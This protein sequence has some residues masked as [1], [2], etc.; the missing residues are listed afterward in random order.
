MTYPIV[1]LTLDSA[2]SYVMQVIL[3]VVVVAI[4]GVVI[5]VVIIGVVVVVTIIRVVV[6][7]GVFAIIKLSFVIIGMTNY[8]YWLQIT[9]SSWSFVSII[10]GQMTYLVIDSTPDCA[11]IGYESFCPSILLLMEIIRAI[12][13]DVL[14]VIAFR[15]SAIWIYLMELSASAIVV[16]CVSRAVA[17][18][19]AT[20][21]LM[22]A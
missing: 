3:V 20:S 15:L 22:A 9:S 17:I 1:S 7:I 8:R 18:L 12:V 5:V 11:S 14:V 6:V 16:V 4:V 13:T 10:L 21:F 2:R 19:S